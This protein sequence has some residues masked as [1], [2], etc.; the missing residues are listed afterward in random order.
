MLS[1]RLKRDLL[2]ILP[3]PVIWFVSGAFFI[4]IEYAA[5]E[6]VDEWT[7][8]AIRV[9]L[10][11]FIFAMLTVIVVGFVLGLL[12][13]RLVD[14]W[15]SGISFGRKLLYKTITYIVFFSVFILIAYPV[16]AAFELNTSILDPKVWQ[17]YAEFFVSKTNFSTM[18]QMSASQFLAVF[19]SE[20]GD[21]MGHR[22]LLN[23]FTGKY[24]RP[25]QEERIFMFVDMRS[26]TA[27][28]EKLGHL[29]YFRM[30]KAFFSDISRAIVN[31]G[32]EIYQYAGD[33]VLISWPMKSKKENADVIRCFFGMKKDLSQRK[34]WYEEHFHLFPDFKAGIHGGMVTAGEI[35]E[36]RKEIFFTSD[37]LHTTARIQSMCN[38]LGVDVL[39]SKDVIDQVLLPD[40]IV[41]KAIGEVELR[42]K[43]AR[44]ELFEIGKKE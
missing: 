39:V 8:T 5:V 18:L 44:V 17:R 10:S 29:E 9:D 21:H 12:E 40:S 35:G 32:G 24:H 30:L 16:A 33:E 19:Y 22:P 43:T 27:I 15:F 7:D 14:K 2:R 23:F 20:I 37:V 31:H 38:S 1:P 36:V 41:I 3:F 42:G 26:S 28:A 34:S 25:I 6:N 11:I 13:I 4:A